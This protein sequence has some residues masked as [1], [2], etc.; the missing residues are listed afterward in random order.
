M[1]ALAG[2]CLSRGQNEEPLGA[3]PFSAALLSLS[4]DGVLAMLLVSQ[5]VEVVEEIVM[6]LLVF[7][8]GKVGKN[9]GSNESSEDSVEYVDTLLHMFERY[10][11]PYSSNVSYLDHIRGMVFAQLAHIH[12]TTAKTIATLLM[13][14]KISI[15]CPTRYLLDEIPSTLH[16]LLLTSQMTAYNDPVAILSGA[17]STALT[18]VAKLFNVA[19]SESYAS[20]DSCMSVVT[21]HHILLPIV[22]SIG[23]S[24]STERVL[25]GTLWDHL[26]ALQVCHVIHLLGVSNRMSDQKI[27]FQGHFIS[28]KAALITLFLPYYVLRFFVLKRTSLLGPVAVALLCPLLLPLTSL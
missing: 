22:W 11:A 26:R 4:Q 16:Y 17:L 28:I 15:T 2:L 10:T 12:T 24:T 9:S 7:A 8:A 13:Q 18:S 19:V 21:F 3:D 25:G 27:S 23:G 1:T 20:G 6:P 5:A 14:H